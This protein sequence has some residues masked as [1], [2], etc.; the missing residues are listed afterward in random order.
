MN[1]FYVLPPT[2]NDIYHYGIKRKSGR[3]PWGSGERPYQSVNG[4]KD[5]RTNKTKKLV[6]SDEY[7][8]IRTREKERK[9]ELEGVKDKIKDKIKD[10]SSKEIS[11][12]KK[13][14]H[15]NK[16]RFGECNKVCNK[17]FF[18]NKSQCCNNV[19]TRD[20]RGSVET[21]VRASAYLSLS[22]IV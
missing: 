12:E 14:R 10:P 19:K 7:R 1:K 4:G 9:K 3:Y 16:G 13:I 11:S 18:P 17:V 8:E 20:I 21:S 15:F 22:H 5:D 6:S 2:P